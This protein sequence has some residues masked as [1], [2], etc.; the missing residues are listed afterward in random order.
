M[1]LDLMYVCLVEVLSAPSKTCVYEEIFILIP[2][3]Y[4]KVGIFI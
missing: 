1:W 3:Y 4:A 2:I